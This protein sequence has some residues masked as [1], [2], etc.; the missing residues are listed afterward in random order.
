MMLYV[1]AQLAAAG[2]AFS[3]SIPGVSYEGGVL[4]GAIIVLV[5]TTIGGFRAVCWTDFL[6]ALLMVGTLVVFPIYLLYSHGGYE[7]IATQLQ[8][9]DPGLLR[10]VPQKTGAAFFGFMLGSGALG[11]NFGYPGQPHVLV[12]F[13]ALRDRRVAMVGGVIAFCWAHT[14]RDFLDAARGEDAQQA[15][16]QWWIERIGELFHINQQRVAAWKEAPRGEA[17]AE[18][19]A[20]LRVCSI[21]GRC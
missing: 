16:A 18:H 4:I 21:L 14:R 19:N 1:A 11:I 13:M 17:L 8:G 2:K 10:L 3:V 20:V 5:Y 6:Q 7:F 12:R 9:A 15:W